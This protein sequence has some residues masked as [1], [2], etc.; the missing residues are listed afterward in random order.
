[1]MR[2]YE[3]SNRLTKSLD[4]PL[5]RYL[6]EKI[7]WDD[8]L[9]MIK[10]A[11]GVGK[12][13]LMKQRCK[14]N[15]PE[16]LYASLDQLYFNEHTITEL[17]DYHYKHGGTH[18]YLDEVHLYPRYNWEQEL[19][20][21]YDS[22]PG[23]HI[24]FT[25]SSLLQLNSKI[26]DLSRRVA[27]YELRGLS[28]REYLNFTGNYRFEPL[29]LTDILNHHIAI[30][31]DIA[32]QVRIIGEFEKYLR[33]GYYPF[34]LESS[35][36]TYSQRV[37]RLVLSVIDI[38]IPA[39]A[40]IEYETQLKLKKLLVVLAE[41]VPF[42]PNMAKLGRDIEVTRNQLVKFFTLLNDGAILRT[43]TDTSTQPKRAAKPGK[44]LFDNPSVMQALG[45][46]NK[47]GTVRE[48]FVA[49][50]LS[51]VG[52]LYA[53]DEGDFSLDKEKL[54]EVGGKNKGFSQIA[55]KPDSYI[56]AD[57][58]ESGM[59]NKIPIWLTGFLY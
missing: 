52:N 19:K 50:M 46:I 8:R 25:G 40:E 59:G 16:G 31:G 9:I 23:F 56:L 51:N 3:I 12:T 41:Q 27:V 18:L 20:N 35:D 47:T 43:L 33:K 54:F 24:V 53:S 55:D 38:D 17:A 2:I 6:Y 36:I 21:I 28:L 58:I 44:I 10:G 29:S 22:Y 4:A 57:N 5:H 1:M 30:A 26:A 48:S 34:F 7:A 37:E 15:G 32:S 13:T 11:R 49:S 39:V 14:E 45:I 42:V